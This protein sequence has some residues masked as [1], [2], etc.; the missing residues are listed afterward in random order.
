MSRGLARAQMELLHRWSADRGEKVI[1]ITGIP[2]YYRQ[3]GDAMALEPSQVAEEL[4]ECAEGRSPPAAA[5]PVL[6]RCCEIVGIELGFSQLEDMGVVLAYEL[7]RYLEDTELIDWQTPSV[8]VLARPL[9]EAAGGFE[10]AVRAR[11]EDRP[12]EFED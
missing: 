6:E 3:F 11:K 10:E 5:A 9:T 1:G 8:V 4:K 7:A 12:P 2:W